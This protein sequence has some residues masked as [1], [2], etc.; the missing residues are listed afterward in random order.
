MSSRQTG[1]RY[2]D[3]GS[4]RTGYEHGVSSSGLQNPGLIASLLGGNK[5]QGGPQMGPNGQVQPGMYKG[6]GGIFG[7]QSRINAA[8]LNQ[9]LSKQLLAQQH[10]KDISKQES[11]QRQS[12]ETLKNNLLEH[13]NR[14]T[15]INSIATKLGIPVDQLSES[16]AKEMA[17]NAMQATQNEGA[18]LKTPEVKQATT[19]GMVAGLQAPAVNNAKMLDLTAP[20]GGISMRTP[21]NG[22][23]GAQ[24]QGATPTQTTS[25]MGSGPINPKTGLPMMQ[26]PVT[27]QAYDPASAKSLF[28]SGSNDLWDAAKNIQPPTQSPGQA[29]DAQESPDN[30]YTKG[31]RQNA[32]DGIST[33]S[34]PQSLTPDMIQQAVQSGDQGTLMKLYQQLMSGPGIFG[35]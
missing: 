7:G 23:P 33:G 12:E 15:Q 3:N 32:L 9:E 16:I 19:Q 20:S 2:M 6:S 10:E 29:T 18:S 27:R 17:S 22:I 25:M 21:L 4:S 30:Y 28:P 35:Q 5:L 24:L 1:S 34:G 13:L 26:T 8:L 31:V 14:S 11:Q